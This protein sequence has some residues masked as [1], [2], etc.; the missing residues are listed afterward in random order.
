MNEASSTGL[1]E[2]QRSQAQKESDY[3]D[4]EVFGSMP[5]TYLN[6]VDASRYVDFFPLA[7]Q[8]HENSCVAHGKSLNVAIYR[9][10]KYGVPYVQ[11]APAFLYRL[12]VNL[13]MPGMI[14]MNANDITRKIGIPKYADLPTP[15]TEDAVN[16]LVIPQAVFDEAAQNK[17]KN[18]ISAS[19]PTSIDSIAFAV[20]ILGVPVN[21]LIFSTIAE[22]AQAV[23]TI[24]NAYLT[25][26]A[27]EVRHCI[28]VLPYSAY[29][30]PTD[31]KRY[32]IIQDSAAFG[33]IQF[34][35]VSEDFIKA[36]CYGADYIVDLQTV[37]HENIPKYNFGSNLTIGSSGD[38]VKVLQSI[39]Q[40]MGFFPSIVNGQPFNPTG[41]Y[42]GMTKNAVMAF[43]NAYAD[44]ILKPLG[45]TQGT[46]V[47]G[48]STRQF[49]NGLSG[50][51]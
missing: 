38:D 49:L 39:L 16:N 12:R 37:S 47:F 43:Q 25:K 4:S 31:G 29:T 13:P 7:N 17:T 51:N 40:G 33:G 42:G 44:K 45:L 9:N 1:I 34:R 50:Y 27:A 48:S 19:D 21:I 11:L 5:I 32:V 23:P 22:W 35:H 36:R 6:P 8:L 14:P 2:D 18:W 3:K 20:N 46:G 30:N 10:L 15:E 26:D 24:Q 28:T 41:Y